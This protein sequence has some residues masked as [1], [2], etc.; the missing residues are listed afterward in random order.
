MTRA[1]VDMEI[2]IV[3]A[4]IKGMFVRMLWLG[5]SFAWFVG[6]MMVKCL[7]STMTLMMDIF[8]MINAL[9]PSIYLRI[10][11]YLLIL[12]LGY[13][14]LTR[15]LIDPVTF[16]MNDLPFLADMFEACVGFV[17]IFISLF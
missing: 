10:F 4:E 17:Y 6:V 2:F 14:L 7:R 11:A 3:A 8:M 16:I 15:L 5:L 1:Y 13:K 9:L 12:L